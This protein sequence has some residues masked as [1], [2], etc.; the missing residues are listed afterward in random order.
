LSD[1]ET[2]GRTA[3]NRVLAAAGAVLVVIGLLCLVVA[4]HEPGARWLAASSVALVILGVWLITRNLLRSVG[5]LV[6]AVGAVWTLFQ[7]VV[8]VAVISSPQDAQAPPWYAALV[9]GLAG[10]I[11]IVVGLLA[12]RRTYRPIF[13]P[14][15]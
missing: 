2:R 15:R 12:I 3:I 14:K 9:G 8:L 7:V 6:V 10:L 13:P 4:A 5:M 11:A 1:A